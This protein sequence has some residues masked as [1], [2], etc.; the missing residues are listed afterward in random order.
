[1]TDHAKWDENDKVCKCEDPTAEYHWDHCHAETK[2]VTNSQKWGYG[3]I[4]T[5]II[6]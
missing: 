4:A 3:V 6:R 1:M 5:A 2:K